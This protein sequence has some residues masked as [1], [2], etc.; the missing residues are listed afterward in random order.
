MSEETLISLDELKDGDIVLYELK[1]DPDFLPFTK[2][3]IS[4]NFYILIDKLICF[5]EES[6]IT[7]AAL[8]YDSNKVIEAIIPT[9]RITEKITDPEYTLHVRRVRN[10][11]DGAVVLDYLPQ[12][13]QEITD[14]PDSYAMIMSAVAALSCLFKAKIKENDDLAALSKIIR[15]VLFK[16]AEWI[17]NKK[18]PISSGDDNWFCS[19][20]VY[21]TY[22]AAAAGL[23][24]K[25]YEIQ[26][27][28]VSTPLTDTLI[29]RIIDRL[30]RNSLKSVQNLLEKPMDENELFQ[31]A[32]RFFHS[33]PNSLTAK[34]DE[35]SD[36]DC[37]YIFSFINR[38]VTANTALS[39]VE[40]EMIKFQSAFVMP[41]DLRDC[42]AEG[43]LIKDE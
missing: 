40:K 8:V 37:D 41:S 25:D 6:R 21:Y 22:T 26:L 23:G 27:P 11:K 14:D 20:L 15:F 16:V 7:H 13:P 35:L 5:A 34:R 24:D 2:E 4:D 39:D 17:D 29:H 43:Y 36:D 32:E 42:L 9:V 19:Q 18:L 38:F 33:D 30:G 3:N 10:G 31:I 1:E 28:D 12:F